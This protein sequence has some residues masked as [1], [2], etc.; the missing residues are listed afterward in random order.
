MENPPEYVINKQWSQGGNSAYRYL[1]LSQFNFQLQE[2]N[3]LYRSKILFGVSVYSDLTVIA[4][5]QCSTD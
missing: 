5:V 1:Y 4:A 2:K 3:V